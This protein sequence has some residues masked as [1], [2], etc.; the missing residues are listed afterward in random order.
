MHPAIQ[1][2]QTCVLSAVLKEVLST[3]LSL[4]RGSKK[5][6]GIILTGKVSSLWT[7]RRQDACRHQLVSHEYA[8]YF[9]ARDSL[10]EVLRRGIFDAV[11]SKN[12]YDPLISNET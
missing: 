10:G 7:A 8:Q 9:S 12:T 6:S 3:T 5:T 2:H 4:S 11:T 1:H